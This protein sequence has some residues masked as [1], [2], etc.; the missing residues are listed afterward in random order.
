M[1]DNNTIRLR[2]AGFKVGSAKEQI[3][4]LDKLDLAVQGGEL[5]AIHGRSGSGKSTLLSIIAGLQAVT[6]GEI[7]VLGQPFHRLSDEERTHARRGRIGFIYQDFQLLPHL[8]AW[9]NAVLPLRLLGRRIDEGAVRSRFADFGLGA[10]RRHYPAQLSGG[11]QQRVAIMR[12]MLVKPKILLADEPTGNLDR[13]TARAFIDIL[14]DAAGPDGAS[15]AV[16]T[17]DEDLI[18]RAD[19]RL[20]LN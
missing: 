20:M 9:E 10:R 17:H 7:D 13:K 3:V 18:E 12:A 16:A 14:A 11:E 2:Q 1:S 4:I 5:L 19:K 15:V 8:N 6:S